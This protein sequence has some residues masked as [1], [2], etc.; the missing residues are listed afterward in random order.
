MKKIHYY[1]MVFQ[2]REVRRDLMADGVLLAQASLAITQNGD[3][4]SLY[5]SKD[6]RAAPGPVT[7]EE[8]EARIK[9][10]QD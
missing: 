1:A 4:R 9:L 10:H 2:N 3:D 6:R 7:K 8:A 5:V